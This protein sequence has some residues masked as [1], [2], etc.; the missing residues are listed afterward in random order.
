MG[1]AFGS[2]LMRH[3]TDTVTVGESKQILPGS[4]SRLCLCVFGPVSQKSY[5]EVQ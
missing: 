5:A 4:G 1:L 3:S 2:G